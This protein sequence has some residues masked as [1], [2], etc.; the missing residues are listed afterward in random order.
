M[1]GIKEKKKY[2][3]NLDP[4]IMKD[5]KKFWKYVKPLFT[6]KSKSKS[7]ITLIK[8]DQIISDEQ[9]VAETL[10][11]YFVNAVQNLNIEKFCTVEDR[12]LNLKNP[13]EEIDDI[14]NCYKLHPSVVMIK[15]KVKLEK[16]FKFESI[17]EEKMHNM[18]KSYCS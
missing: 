4:A 18:I 1:R 17:D 10:N 5:S 7:T 9:Q 16:T 8:G 6:G 13:D 2:F 15:N 11:M 3:N 12:N 14:L